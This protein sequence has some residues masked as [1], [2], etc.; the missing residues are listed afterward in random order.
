MQS[1]KHLWSAG[2]LACGV[3]I[4]SGAWGAI[5]VTSVTPNFGPIGTGTLTIIRGTG[6]GGTTT[7]VTFGGV[8]GTAFAV[9]NATQLTVTSPATVTVPGTVNL[10]VLDTGGNVTIVNGWRWTNP[11]LQV[12]ATA[13][14]NSA[15]S[16]CWDATT[17][18]DSADT[19]HGSGTDIVPFVWNVGAFNGAGPDPVAPISTASSYQLS[20]EYTVVVKNQSVVN[21]HLCGSARGA[22][23]GTGTTDPA[24]GATAGWTQRLAGGATAADEYAL[25]AQ[26]DSAVGS[27][28]RLDATVP[29]QLLNT[30]TTKVLTPAGAGQSAQVHLNFFTPLTTSAATSDGQQQITVTLTGQRD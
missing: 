24:L 30:G 1:A 15:I 5:T 25:D 3:L 2:L 22:L 11:A 14:I 26:L 12:V 4:S 23:S 28:V 6:F 8:A 21:V 20:N 13:R 16:I 7:G 27:A 18:N 19:A 9:N 17:V 10:V 29:G